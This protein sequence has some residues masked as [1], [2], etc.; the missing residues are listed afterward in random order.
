MSLA[1]DI[2]LR[3]SLTGQQAGFTRLVARASMLGMVLGVASLITV[4]SVMNGFAAEL[5]SRILALVP[6]VV[7]HAPASALED[8]ST[9]ADDLSDTP[10]VTGM[11]PFIEDTVLLE[12]WG[13]QRGATLTGIELA[14]QSSVSALNSAIV[15]GDLTRLEK[16]RFTVA[17]GAGLARLLGVR[18]GDS[19]DVTLP[20]LSVTPLGVFPRNRRLEV[21]AEFEVGSEL[22]ARQIYVSLDSARRLFAR[23]GV[24]GLQVAVSNRDQTA[25]VT[26]ALAR[27]LPEGYR[28]SDW[29]SSQGSLFTAIAM[30]KVTVAILLLAVVAVAAFNIVS[31]LTM[32]VTEKQSDIAVL[33]VMGL[34]SR[35]VLG[36]FLG[37]GLLLGALGIVVGAALGIVLATYIS[38][39]S[40]WL[41]QLSGQPLF[42][43][44]VYYIGRLPSVMH[45][46]DVWLTVVSALVLAALAS[47]YPAWRAA[48]IHP[49]EALNHG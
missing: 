17:V 18:V 6:H 46:S 29:R 24:D 34:S 41:E 12:A 19:L 30:E 13:R 10:G 3:Y 5:H 14:S 44:Q 32:S 23:A 37:H 11:A 2:V 4:M 42:D 49:I 8:W 33:R 31:S 43:P 35:S 1:W 36:I 25:A 22:D 47:L 28:V 20:V 39:I 45:W 15:Q 48:R 27:R 9:L 40:L 7:V 26:Q 21:V 16:E 38:D